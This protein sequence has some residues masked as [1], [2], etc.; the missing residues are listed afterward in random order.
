MSCEGYE[1][2]IIQQIY[3]IHNRTMSPKK[4]LG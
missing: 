2:L 3:K 1:V 4:L